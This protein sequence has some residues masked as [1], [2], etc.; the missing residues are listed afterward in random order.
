MIVT[1]MAAPRLFDRKLVLARRLR[2]ERMG[3]ETFLLDGVADDLVERLSAVKRRFPLALDLGTPGNALAAALRRSHQADRII[4]C[5]PLVALRSGGMLRVAADEEALPFAVETLDLVVSALSLQ[6]V[7]DLPGAF[8][9]IRRA[10]KP[11]GLFLAALVGGETLGELRESLAIAESEIEGG[12]SPRVSPFVDVRTLGSLLQRA[13][14]A[15]PV[16]DVERTTARYRNMRALLHDLRRMGAANALVERS[17]KPLPR[18][19]L[20]R[21]EE[22]YTARFADPDGRLRATF[23]TLWLSAWAPHASQQKPLAPGSAKMRLAD[24]LGTSERPAG[25]KAGRRRR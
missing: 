2:A 8:A 9:Q 6:W 19:V 20:A 5:E 18:A 22:I 3:L 17:R 15:L 1:A 4:A 10:L 25:E 13:G 14:L 23:D 7:N 24:A 12:A 11:D 21:A 16:T